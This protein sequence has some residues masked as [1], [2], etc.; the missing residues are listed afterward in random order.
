MLTGKA[1]VRRRQCGGGR[2]ASTSTSRRPRRASSV[3]ALP[4]ELE[5]VVLKALAKDPAQRYSDADSFIKDLEVVEARL[6]Q[7]PVDVESTAV[8]APM[9]ATTAPTA[10]AP[11]RR[12]PRAPRRLRRPT[13]SR[14]RLHRRSQSRPPSRRTAPAPLARGRAARRAGRRLPC[15]RSCCSGPRT[16]P[17]CRPSSGRPWSRPGQRVDRAGFDVEVEAAHRPGAARLRVRAVAQPGPGGGRGI[18]RDAVRV[19]RPQHRQG[20]GRA[21]ASR[22]RMRAGAC[23]APTCGRTSS[24][25]PRRRWPRGS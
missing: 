22:R 6:R 24:A 8:F 18:D 10:L 3:P 13:S 12:R 1:A 9:A 19:E 4:P 23:G 15:W 11:C 5:A 21:S 25:R 14:L 16:R 2:A 20:A 7:G 17:R